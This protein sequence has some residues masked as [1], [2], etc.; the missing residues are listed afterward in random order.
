MKKVLLLALCL[1]LAGLLA[2][3]G[4]FAAEFTQAV[5]EVVSAL[6]KTVQ[7]LASPEPTADP[8]AFRVT[9]V[10]PDSNSSERPMLFPGSE[11]ERKIAVHNN[12]TENTAYFRI[13]F[14][15]QA[16]A[17]PHVTLYFNDDGTYTWLKEWRD[18]TIGGRDYKLRI[19]TYTTALEAGKTS[20]AALLS[21]AMSETVTSE[22]MVQIDEDFLQ[23]QVLAIN[24]NDFDENTYTTAKAALDAALPIDS[25]DFNPFN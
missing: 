16:E 7:G 11:V 24:A 19:G 22:Q 10:Y 18:I 3:N 13:A 6:F 17:F 4:T 12:S 14:A 1:V 15:V 23:A 25:T 5:S 21:V 9:L 2:V 8:T 20:S